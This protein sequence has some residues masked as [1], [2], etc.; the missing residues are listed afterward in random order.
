MDNQTAA[1]IDAAQAATG[2]RQTGVLK[3]A[4]DGDQIS[5]SDLDYRT[6]FFVE[7]CSKRLARNFD[8][9]AKM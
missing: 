9:H 8:A 1:A 6:Q 4:L 2:R 3:S 7:Q 5:R